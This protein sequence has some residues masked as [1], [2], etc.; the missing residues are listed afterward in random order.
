[1]MPNF[2]HDLPLLYTGGTGSGTTRSSVGETGVL[3]FPDPAARQISTHQ[4]TKDREIANFSKKKFISTFLGA[5]W[6]DFCGFRAAGHI[7][8]CVH[9]YCSCA[10]IL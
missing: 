7:F 2:R 5:H 1:M 3:P 6:G 8:S 4:Q 10:H 9:I